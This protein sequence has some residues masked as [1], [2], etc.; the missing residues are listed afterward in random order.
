MTSTMFQEALL[1]FHVYF[2]CP[3]CNAVRQVPEQYAGQSG[4]CNTC[5]G[6]ITISA[7]T[8]PPLPHVPLAPH[9]KT[10]YRERTNYF[11]FC[12]ENYER[13]CAQFPKIADE[14]YWHR[15]IQESTRHHDRASQLAF[16]EGLVAEGIPWSLA[17]EYLVHHYAKERDY[18]RAYYFCSVYF[19]SDRWKN[20]Q[21]VGSSYKLLKVMR[22]LQKKLYESHGL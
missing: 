21:C 12:R 9:P 8:A 1:P 3:H 15:R 17:F 10:W 18:Q 22:K 20:P 13:A 7:N 19:L 2:T 6:A 4:A 5:G 11:E 16:W 14:A